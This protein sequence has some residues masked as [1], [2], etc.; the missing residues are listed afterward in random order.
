MKLT[1]IGGGTS[2]WLSALFLKK[3]FPQANITVLASSEIGILGAGEGTTGN[4][5]PFM[6]KLDISIGDLIKNAKATFKNG[7]AFQNWN[8]QGAQDVFFHGFN[9]RSDLSVEVEQKSIEGNIPLLF[10]QKIAQGDCLNDYSL[11]AYLSSRNKVKFAPRDPASPRLTREE[12]YTFDAEGPHL[13]ELLGVQGLHFDARLLASYLQKV[14]CSRGVQYIDDELIELGCSENGNISSL[15]TKQGLNL[16]VW[17][18]ETFP[19]KRQAV[20]N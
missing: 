15:K 3:H 12:M 14:A 7:I 19:S 18:A 4:F 20:V 16:G 6:R 11:T 13:Y 2:G 5:I 8:G 9:D 17:A 10:L 1:I